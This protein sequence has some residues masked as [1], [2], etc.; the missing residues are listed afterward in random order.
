[1]TQNRLLDGRWSGAG[2]SR[3]VSL[4]CWRRVLPHVDHI[5]GVVV[6]VP[7]ARFQGGGV[8]LADQCLEEA[9]LTL[10]DHEVSRGPLLAPKH[11][12]LQHPL[13]IPYHPDIA[14]DLGDGDE[15]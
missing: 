6:N 5:L 11:L 4:T 9:P 7:L 15:A 2:S 10:I 8:G 14:A 1:M 3:Q 12:A 13:S